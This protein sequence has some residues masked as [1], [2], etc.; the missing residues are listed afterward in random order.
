MK[1]EGVPFGT[2]DWT[3]VPPTEHRGETGESW[4]RRIGGIQS[5]DWMRRE[6]HAIATVVG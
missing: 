2:T 5:A 3:S 1:M 6:A 4:R